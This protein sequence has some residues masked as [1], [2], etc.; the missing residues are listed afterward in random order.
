MS[1]NNPVDSVAPGR[2]SA[3]GAAPY[4][5]FDESNPFEAMMVRFDA[6]AELLQL[7]PGMY[8]VLRH[9]EK[10]IIVSVPIQRD[11][12]DVEVFTGY[13]VV[14]NTAR[15]PAKGGVR[16]DTLVTLDEVKALVVTSLNLPGIE[17]PSIEDEA[18]LFGDGLGLDSVDALELV[19]AV[20]KAFGVQIEDDQV[21]R[22]AFVV[23]ALCSGH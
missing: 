12:G 6:A 21:G 7:D 5:Q 4:A 1:E 9:P 23:R 16:F 10:Q 19:V 15:G 8:K 22:E 20:E 2:D 14:H 3:V 11:N 13:R 17:P 18:P